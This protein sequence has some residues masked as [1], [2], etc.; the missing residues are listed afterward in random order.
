[1]GCH[2]LLQ[3]IFPTQGS[4]SGLLHCR[5]ILYRLSHQGSPTTHTA[6]LLGEFWR[7][8]AVLL[9]V[10]SLNQLHQLCLKMCKF[11]DLIP[12]LPTDSE[13]VEGRNSY[14]F[15]SPLGVRMHIQVR[16]PLKRW[17]NMLSCKPSSSQSSFSGWKNGACFPLLSGWAN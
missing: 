7:F 14:L 10:W 12:D 8:R 6:S 16:E 1:M 5:Q 9:K 13:L 4:N 17:G 3:G 15:S 2:F 11:S